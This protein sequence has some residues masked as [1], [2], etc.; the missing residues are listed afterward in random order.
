MSGD[1]VNEDHIIVEED[2]TLFKVPPAKRKQKKDN[3]KGK[4]TPGPSK[5]RIIEDDSRVNIR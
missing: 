5:K 4:G 2:G 3:R 1:S